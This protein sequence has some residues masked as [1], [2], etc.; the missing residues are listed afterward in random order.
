MLATNSKETKVSVVLCTYN[1]AN[2]ITNQLQTIVQQTHTPAEIIIFDDAS[3][4]NTWQILLQWKEKCQHIQLY[5]NE[6]NIGFNNN[7]QQAL[8]AANCPIIAIADQDDVWELTKLE[9]MLAAWV[10][11]DTPIIYCN[12]LRFQQQ[13]PTNPQPIKNYLRYQGVDARKLFFYNTVSGHAMLVKKSFL[14]IVLPFT[15]GVYYDWWM[16]VVASYNGGVTY[17]PDILVY[18]RIHNNNASVKEVISEE[19]SFINY[20]SQVL[21]HLR[22]FMLA[23]NIPNNDAAFLQKLI[24][25]FQHRNNNFYTRWALFLCIFRNSKLLFHYKKRAFPWFSY[26]KHAKRWS[27]TQ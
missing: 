20:R 13:V 2:Y 23:P 19:L 22:Q 15:L 14:P 5:K 4:D 10:N 12:S 3:T 18:Q 11:N 21:A 25:L 16:A 24:Y 1:G 9:K 7:F 8:L 17:V 6:L 27:F 26:I